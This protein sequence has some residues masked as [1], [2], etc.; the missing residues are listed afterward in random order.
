MYLGAKVG[1]VVYYQREHWLPREQAVLVRYYRDRPDLVM[2]NCAILD[3]NGVG[4]H[5]SVQRVFRKDKV[6]P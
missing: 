1:Q 3:F 5:V 2:P 6:Q 4:I